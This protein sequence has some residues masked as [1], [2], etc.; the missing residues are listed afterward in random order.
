MDISLALAARC[1]ACLRTGRSPGA[2]REAEAI[3]A[4]GR[5][6]YERVEDVPP[7]IPLAADARPI[8]W[9]DDFRAGDRF[10]T[11]TLTVD[12]AEVAAFASAYDPQPFHMDS[13]AGAKSMFGRM[14][15]SGWHTAGLTMRLIVTG[16][17]RMGSGVIGVGADELRW[18]AVLPGDRLRVVGEVVE[19]RASANRPDRG[20]VRVRYRTLNQN[21]EE[22]QHIVATHIVLKRPAAG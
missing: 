18:K 15:A 11:G 10:E 3:R 1:D 20:I 5:P 4:R 8:L 21:D 22:A 9:F 6:V 13:E 2:D 17:F 14:V 7:V 12:E 19:A 16:G